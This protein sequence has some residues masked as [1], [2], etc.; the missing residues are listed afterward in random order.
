[1]SENREIEIVGGGNETEGTKFYF[2]GK[3]VGR[4]RRVQMGAV[5]R[6]DGQMWPEGTK[7]VSLRPFRL[8]GKGGILCL[9]V[10]GRC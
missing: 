8:E 5:C 9:K 6:Q 3:W 4:E 2:E 7:V 1:M 10:S